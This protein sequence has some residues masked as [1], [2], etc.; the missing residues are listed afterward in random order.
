MP[1]LEL[2]LAGLGWFVV[3]ELQF[4]FALLVLAFHMPVAV[5]IMFLLVNVAFLKSLIM[6]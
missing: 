2:A 5:G 4:E 3:V 6:M 1:A